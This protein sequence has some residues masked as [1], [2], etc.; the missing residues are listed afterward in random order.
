MRI[1]FCRRLTMPVLGTTP[2]KDKWIMRERL[3]W[4]RLFDV[5]MHDE[6]VS[7]FPP[8]T[9]HTMRAL[10]VITDQQQLGHVV[11]RLYD[12]F[13]VHHKAIETK[14]VFEPIL[15][16]VL[17]AEAADQVIGK[18]GSEGKAALKANTD[19]AY[20]AGAFGAPWFM[21]TRSDGQT[22]CFWGVDHMGQLSDFLGLEKPLASGGWKAVL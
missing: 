15:R 5:P 17:G 9:M 4:A 8:N 14:D 20:D 16:G 18:A 22:D 11:E 12:D 6:V 21:C 7:N 2:D 1:I 3:R 19:K 10:A 13:F